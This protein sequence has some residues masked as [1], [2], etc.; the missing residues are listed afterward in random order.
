VVSSIPTI[1][2]NSGL[3]ASPN[4]LDP[5]NVIAD[6]VD[7]VFNFLLYVYTTTVFYLQHLLDIGLQKGSLVNASTTAVTTALNV[8]VNAYEAIVEWATVFIGIL[9]DSSIAVFLNNL[10]IGT[11]MI[12][13]NLPMSINQVSL[14]VKSGEMSETEG[15]SIIGRVLLESINSL[16]V[17]ATAIVV[18]VLALSVYFAAQTFISELIIPLLITAMVATLLQILMNEGYLQILD[19]SSQFESQIIEIIGS[20][21]AIVFET[22]ISISLAVLCFVSGH[23]QIMLSQTLPIILG[24]AIAILALSVALWSMTIDDTESAF[25]VAIFGLI[26]SIIGFI[27]YFADTISKH[28][29]VGKILFGLCVSNVGVSTFSLYT[30]SVRVMDA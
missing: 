27:P 6:I 14:S 9:I 24:F 28:L 5:L 23:I 13:G 7:M 16:L 8:I 22:I 19:D 1:I 15:A 18:L 10:N 20:E 17:I 29:L 21:V 11:S 4:Y 26:L 25:N 30:A 12:C 3:G 2:Q